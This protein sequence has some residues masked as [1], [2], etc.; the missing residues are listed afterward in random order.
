[1]G[2]GLGSVGRQA[3]H[4]TVQLRTRLSN[5]TNAHRLFEGEFSRRGQ[6]WPPAKQSVKNPHFVMIR[7]N[8][9]DSRCR[10]WPAAKVAKQQLTLSVPF[11]LSSALHNGGVGVFWPALYMPFIDVFKRCKLV[12]L[13]HESLVRH[14]SARRG[15][16]R[17]NKDRSQGD[18]L[19]RGGF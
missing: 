3:A 17:T 19:G 18:R 1:M 12:S 2:G 8:G 9:E 10:A 5:G 14:E 4:S 11:W 7:R 16:T 6:G 13:Q 15:R